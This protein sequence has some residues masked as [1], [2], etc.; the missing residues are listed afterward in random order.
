MKIVIIVYSQKELQEILQVLEVDNIE[1][2][3]QYKGSE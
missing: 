2:E 3:I 1:I